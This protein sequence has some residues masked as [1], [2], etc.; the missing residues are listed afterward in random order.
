M[1]CLLPCPP[2]QA[3]RKVA[4]K[5][6]QNVTVVEGD[7]CTFVPP[8]GTANLV[9]F[10]YSLSSKHHTLRPAAARRAQHAGQR[11]WRLHG[12]LATM[13]TVTA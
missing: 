1:P 7:A 8:E 2:V 13:Q 6:W 5:G 4:E 12:A 11:Q 10:S 3:K 9:S